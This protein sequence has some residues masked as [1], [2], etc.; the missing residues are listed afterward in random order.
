M[1][2]RTEIDGTTRFV[3]TIGG[4]GTAVMAYAWRGPR[5]PGSVRREP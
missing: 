2:T 1:R 3:S 4:I 5:A